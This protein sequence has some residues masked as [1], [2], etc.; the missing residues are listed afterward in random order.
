MLGGGM[1]QA[2]VLAAAGMVA[3]EEGPKRLHVDHDN[4]RALAAKLAAIPGIEL[5]PSKVQTNIVIF[6]VKPSG[7]SSD[8]FLARCRAHG[9]LAVPV[10]AD[11]I[12]MVTHL[13]VD[14]GD[15]DKATE[16]VESVLAVSADI[17]GKT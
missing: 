4:A 9:V 7:L 2:G 5:D 17:T 8:D 14:R 3:L 1:R 6:S 16:I 15:I 10:D 13:D 11:R 12:R